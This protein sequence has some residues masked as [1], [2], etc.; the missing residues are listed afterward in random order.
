MVL[1]G[2]CGGEDHEGARCRSVARD[3]DT[4]TVWLWRFTLDEYI[5]FLDEDAEIEKGAANKRRVLRDP[6]VT[7][8]AGVQSDVI[9]HVFGPV[10]RRPGSLNVL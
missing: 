3:V 4:V 5:I 2:W 8:V 1:E 7:S 10:S 9:P 6:F